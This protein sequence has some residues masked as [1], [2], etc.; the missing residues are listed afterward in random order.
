VRTRIAIAIWSVALVVCAWLLRADLLPLPT[1]I[2]IL[3]AAEATHV[4]A[5][6]VLYGVLAALANELLPRPA[7]AAPALTLGVAFLQELAQV[8]PFGRGLDHESFYDLFVDG[9]AVG[10]VLLI[11]RRRQKRA[12]I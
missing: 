9:L 4:V 3:A 12:A 11:L 7:W 8:V 10:A 5:H 2:A 1:P 6:L